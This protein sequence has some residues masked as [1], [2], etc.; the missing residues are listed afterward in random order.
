M[1]KRISELMD[2]E[3]EHLAGEAWM[4]ASMAALQAGVP[5]VGREGSDLVKVYPDG[6]VE[7][8]AVG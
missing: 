2:K 6:R 7:V 4:E 3:F 5:I 1:A 8:L